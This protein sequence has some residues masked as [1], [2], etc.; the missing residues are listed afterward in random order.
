MAE[1]VDRGLRKQYRELPRQPGLAARK[2]GDANATLAQ[3]AKR[4][5]AKYEVPYLAHAPMEPLNCLVSVTAD[6]CE[7]SSGT[8]FQ[9]MDAV[10]AAKSRAEAG[11]GDD[12]HALLGGGFAAGESGFDS[13][14]KQSRFAKAVGKPVMTVWTREDDIRGGYYRRC[15]SIAL[16]GSMRGE[17]QSPRRTSS[18]A[19]DPGRTPFEQFLVKNSIDATSVEGGEDL[20]CRSPLTSGCTARAGRARAVVA[21]VRPFAHRLRGG[22]LRR[23]AGRRG[24]PRSARF[25]ARVLDPS[26]RGVARCSTSSPRSPAGQAAAERPRARL[27]VHDRSAASLHRWPKCRSRT[28][29]CGSTEW[30]PRCIA[31]SR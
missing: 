12:P 19:V 9:T 17:Y 14:T 26:T 20:P 31:A 24:G 13:S 15:G 28:S 2:D 22:E 16:A 27:A 3:A 25:P 7:I 8:Q 1:P 10:R 5:E 6:K 29:G 18:S 23:R 30:S 11:A 4:I 21:F